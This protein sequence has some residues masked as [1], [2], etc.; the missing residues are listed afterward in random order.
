MDYYEYSDSENDV[1]DSPTEGFEKISSSDFEKLFNTE[2]KETKRHVSYDPGASWNF[3][4]D[5][6]EDT[7]EDTDYMNVW[8]N[9]PKHTY[10]SNK[11]NKYVKPYQAPLPEKWEI[12]TH[13]FPSEPPPAS[14]ATIDLALTSLRLWASSFGL[15]RTDI[16]VYIYSSRTHSYVERPRSGAGNSI[17]VYDDGLRCIILRMVI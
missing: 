8:E 2:E 10:K 12:V 14:F 5:T 15:D 6:T 11:P 3:D 16:G 9:R 13:N 4:E 7:T 17:I 1:P